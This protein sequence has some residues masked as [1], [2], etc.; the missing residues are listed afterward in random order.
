[1]K[2]GFIL[3]SSLLLFFSMAAFAQVIPPDNFSDLFAWLPKF[4]E[5]L[6]AGN[7]TIAAGIMI[8]VIVLVLRQFVLVRLKVSSDLLPIVTAV[9]GAFSFAGLSMTS[10]VSVGTALVNGLTAG[11]F[12]S[13]AWDLIGKYISKLVLGDKYISPK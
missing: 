4:M 2:N 11:I 9:I 12:A 1:M 13:G 7:W 10:G 6:T 8:M 5:A 3:Y